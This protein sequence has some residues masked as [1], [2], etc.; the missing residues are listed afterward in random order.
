MKKLFA[1]DRPEMLAWLGLVILTTSVYAQVG[2]FAFVN[3]DDPYYV[4]DNPKVQKGLSWETVSWSFSDATRITNYWVPLTWLSFLIDFELYGPRAGGYHVTNML[5]HLAS[6]L[7]LFRFCRKLDG[8]V[9]KSFFVAAL[10]ALHPLHVESVAWVTERKDVLSTFFWMLTMLSYFHYV[11]APSS[12]RYGATFF[13]FMAGLMAKPMLVTLPFVLLLLDFWPFTR[14]SFVR[15]AAPDSIKTGTSIL[16]FRHCVLEKIPFFIAIG[17]ISTVTF[18]SQEKGGAVKSLSDFPLEVRLGN[19]MISYVSYIGKA[20]WPFDLTVIYPHP[21]KLP[22]FI[23]MASFLLL[24][25]ATLTVLKKR[26]TV[27]WM[28]TGWFWYV[29]TLLPVSGVVVIGPHA[30]ADRYAYVS[31]I[32]IYI[33]VAWGVP[34]LVSPWRFRTAGLSLMAATLLLCFQAAAWIQVRY[35][36]NSI[37]LFEH[38]LKVAVPNTAVHMNLGNAYFE[39]ER[40]QDA[41]RQ[42]FEVIRIDPINHEA[43][44][45]VGVIFEKIG[46]EEKA[47]EWYQKAL[48]LNPAFV[49]SHLHIGFLLE[50]LGRDELAASRFARVLNLDSRSAEGHFGLGLVLLKKG[51]LDRSIYHFR[52]AIEIDPSNA[53]AHNNLGVALARKGAMDEAANCFQKAVQLDKGLLDAKKNYINAVL[54]M[55]RMAVQPQR[56]KRLEP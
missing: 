26:R 14:C 8:S 11:K 1:D 5:L 21:G 22:G 51:R 17:I 3:F 20:F 9:W 23:V 43:V 15:D 55:K 56:E 31:M 2:Q 39:A 36:E 33:I 37:T 44:N 27:P 16:P 52:Q 47:L 7:L 54:L 46:K 41:M 38:A 50:K 25:A 40:L 45:N 30:M 13:L 42:Y 19:V 34:Q 10:F 4:A 49:E 6:C 12:A 48:H 18:W 35:W 28:T 53:D 24:L 32:G 29:I